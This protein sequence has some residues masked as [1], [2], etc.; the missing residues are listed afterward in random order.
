VLTKA[1]AWLN[2]AEE[3][4]DENEEGEIV[5]VTL[6]EAQRLLRSL[7]HSAEAVQPKTP[8]FGTPTTARPDLWLQLAQL[9]DRGVSCACD[10]FARL[11]VQLSWAGHEVQEGRQHASP[12][13]EAAEQ[14]VESAKHEA[15]QTCPLAASVPRPLPPVEDSVSHDTL[16]S[17]EPFVS[18]IAP[19][20]VPIETHS[21]PEPLLPPTAL[22]ERPLVPEPSAV[23][24]A[25]SVPE[26]TEAPE[27]AIISSATLPW[28]VHFSTNRWTLSAST[29]GVLDKVSEVLLRHPQALVR[30]EGHTDQRGA[31][32]CNQTLSDRRTKAVKEYL[33]KAGI[34]PDH[35]STT[36][37][38][39]S[40]PLTRSRQN[41]ELAR[42]RR[43]VI[44]VTNI[45]ELTLEEQESDLQMDQRKR[46]KPS[47]QTELKAQE[48]QS[49]KVKT[50]QSRETR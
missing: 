29:A 25:T 34:N 1:E 39:K 6:R 10:S 18:S 31:A 14:L 33:V 45:E 44:V 41:R 26:P 13:I 48:H 27:T 3:E 4:Y 22:P 40:R 7:D 12:Y 20:P 42:N 35:I 49:N 50:G 5:D 38:G 24:E 11:E 36:A 17:P 21:A 30:L 46:R 15:D 32:S 2:V 23:A 8:L 19:A 43:V 28:A 9:R 16:P 47:R 37:L